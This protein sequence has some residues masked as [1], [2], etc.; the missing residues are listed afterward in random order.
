[1]HLTE[2]ILTGVKC[3][4]IKRTLRPFIAILLAFCLGGCGAGSIPVPYT[5]SVHETGAAAVQEV[6]FFAAD[7]CVTEGDVNTIGI[8]TAEHTCAGLF[9]VSTHETLY[10]KNVYER[11]NPAS[12]T[13][14]MT[15]L[16]AIENGDLTKTITASAN[17][18]IT[19]RGAQ[20]IGIK[21]GDSMTLDQ[22]LHILLIYSANDVAV[23]IAEN[24][25][26]SV[27]RFTQMM[28]EKARALGATGTHFV[29]PHG[30]TDKAH[31]VTAYD[32]YLIFYEAMQ[33]TEF[34]E[35]IDTAQYSS[36]YHQADG[37]EVPVDIRSTVG[38]LTGAYQVPEAVSV[39]GGKSGT[40][41][42]AGH[43]L[44]LYL[45]DRAGQE[46]VSVVMHTPDAETLDKEMTMIMQNLNHS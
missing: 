34:R 9:N 8:S 31:Y 1:M 23:M 29:N 11:L 42:A 28:N 22:A 4:G 46:Y 27:E 26:G 36:S 24:V 6:P 5:P 19:E 3:T 10:A 35:I 2:E 14:V 25:A 37:T 33:Y 20:K 15:A 21:E 32:M 12:L 45:R 7:L 30:L 39:V 18:T 38:Y 16:V 41:A 17:V 44:I 13:K 40:T 43:C